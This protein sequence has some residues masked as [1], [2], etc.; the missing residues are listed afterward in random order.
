MSWFFFPRKQTVN[1]ITIL[2]S[3]DRHCVA[4]Y[5]GE[6][7]KITSVISAEDKRTPTPLEKK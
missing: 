1:I 3:K 7:D 2:V 6:L 5:L 4:S